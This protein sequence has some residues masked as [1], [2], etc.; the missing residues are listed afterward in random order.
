[1]K[2]GIIGAMRL[3]VEALTAAVTDKQEF[4]LSGIPYTTGKLM[5]KDVVIAICGPGKVNAA[6]CTEAMILRFAPDVIINTGVAGGIG[7]GLHIL[8]LVIATKVGQ[9]DVDTVGAGDPIGLIPGINVMYI[10]TDKELS[11][12]LADIA[13]RQ[14][15]T[16]HTG[17][18]AT[19]DQ[20]IASKEQSEKIHR[21][22][23]ENLA[24]E[25]EGGAIGHVCYINKVPFAILRA[26]SD[27]G[28]DDAFID[29]PQ[30]VHIAA[31]R[32]VSIL[33]EYLK[34]A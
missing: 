4:I 25:M 27:G 11:E 33:L 28:N 9:H 3:E 30:F 22:F 8:D 18:V 2:Y 10:D 1:M 17:V 21:T 19:G 20:F 24:A 23:P 14:N 31:E 12:S 7:E 26:I 16:V 32:A 15:N 6:L 5:G 34:T 13:R 29:Y